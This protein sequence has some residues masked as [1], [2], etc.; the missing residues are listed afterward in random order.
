M[1]YSR[2]EVYLSLKQIEIT[3][4]HCIQCV[5]FPDKGFISN[6]DFLIIKLFSSL[7]EL[8]CHQDLTNQISR[9]LLAMT[10]ANNWVTID[11]INS[12]A[13]EIHAL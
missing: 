6:V 13:L 11:V 9:R 8:L 5:Y 10:P 2:T 3:T 7:Q 12:S 4:C 1:E